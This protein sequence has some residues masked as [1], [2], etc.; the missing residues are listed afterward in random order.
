MIVLISS[1][2]KFKIKYEEITFSL[3]NYLSQSL[4][5]LFKGQT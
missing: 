2:P 1:I 5:K 3:R 4:D